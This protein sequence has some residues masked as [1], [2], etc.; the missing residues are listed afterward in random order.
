VNKAGV[1]DC[2][3]VHTVTSVKGDSNAANRNV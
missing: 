1:E 3:S 2:M